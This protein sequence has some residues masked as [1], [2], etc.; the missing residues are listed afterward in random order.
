MKKQEEKGIIKKKKATTT[1][2]KENKE[3]SNKRKTKGRTKKEKL[4][5]FFLD[6]FSFLSRLFSIMTPS[7]NIDSGEPSKISIMFYV[8]IANKEKGKIGLIGAKKK[9]V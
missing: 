8:G 2:K 1:E 5:S 6:L 7:K 9:E 3:T 4:I